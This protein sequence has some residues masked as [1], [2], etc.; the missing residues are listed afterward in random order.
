V[1]INSFAPVTALLLL[2]G[3]A[4]CD[5][6]DESA[7]TYREVWRTTMTSWVNHPLAVGSVLFHTT[8]NFLVLRLVAGTQDLLVGVDA[9]TGE[10][11]GS[12]SWNPPTGPTRLG[13]GFWPG[14]GYIYFNEIVDQ[15]NDLRATVITSNLNV[16]IKNLT[17]NRPITF[18]NIQCNPDF[19]F[20]TEAIEGRQAVIITKNDYSNNTI[21][22]REVRERWIRPS[23]FMSRDALIFE[24][25]NNLDSLSYTCVDAV[26]GNIRW[27]KTLIPGP[28][29]GSL[30]KAGWWT[31]NFSFLLDH[32]ILHNQDPVTRDI[33]IAVIRLADGVIE[34]RATITLAKDFSLLQILRATE[35]GLLVSVGNNDKTLLQ[36]IRGEGNVIWSSE[37]PELVPIYQTENGELYITGHTLLARFDPLR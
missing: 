28:L 10:K 35:G 31:P 19:Y 1:R 29:A 26:N 22:K 4:G 12:I 18:D 33:T 36:K 34:E 20:L 5:E 27:N 30:P 2:L 21:W 3:V 7:G 25:G 13:T 8:D 37:F 17:V 6:S 32:L 16:E 24:R 9:R 14:I 15:G 23:P 11:N